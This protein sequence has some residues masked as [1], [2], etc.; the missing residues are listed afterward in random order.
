ML[1]RMTAFF[2][3]LILCVSLLPCAQAAAAKTLTVSFQVTTYQNRARTLLKQINQFRKEYDLPELTMLADLE[4][5]ALQRA[6]ELFVFFDH[7]RPDLTGYDTAFKE[8]KSLSGAQAV[9]ECVAAGYSKADEV[10]AEWEETAA[11]SLLDEDFTHAGLACVYL[12]DSANEYYWELYLMQLPQNTSAKKAEST[13]KAGTAKNMKVE[14]AKGMYERADNSHKRFELRVDDLNL[15]TKTSAQPTVYL[16]DR[17]DVKIGK[18]ELED[19]TFKSG[20][21]SVFTVNADGTVKKKK[22]G[23]GTL[24]VKSSGLEDAT[25]TVTIGSSASSSSSSASSTAS[26]TA[27][28]IKEAKPELKAK[29]YTN[30]TSL[31][32]YLKGASGYVLYRSTSKTGTYSKVEEEATTKTWT[33]KLEGDDLSRTYYYKVR[34]YKNSNGKRVYS[35]YSDPVRVTP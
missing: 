3:T 16:Y 34:A 28:T 17:Y 29:E 24:T 4:K 10:F 26:V 21:T 1:R 31:S 30:H 18:C 32:V 20:S 5:V 7:D 27:A 13:A 25:C 2:L 11:D 8:Y 35:E 22:N 19:L 6:S 14:I 15:K 23:T 9:A 12:K 33:H